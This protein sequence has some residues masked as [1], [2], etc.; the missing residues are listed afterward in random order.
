MKIREY[1]DQEGISIAELA[2]RAKMPAST[3]V[4]ILISGNPTVRNFDKLK[5][6]SG[7]QI[8]RP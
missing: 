3:V 2:R 1:I 4:T 5:K 6:A 8:S 7:G